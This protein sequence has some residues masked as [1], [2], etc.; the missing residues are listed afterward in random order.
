MDNLRLFLR[1]AED[2][3]AL[4]RLGDE[5]C[6]RFLRLLILLILPL[7]LLLFNCRLYSTGIPGDGVSMTP[8]DLIL[9][10]A[11]TEPLGTAVP[12][13]S[14]AE[15]VETVDTLDRDLGER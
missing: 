14:A 7:L 10:L 9:R 12:S 6:L 8:G 4:I 2:S 13:M 11:S 1:L 5:L 15:A 3:A